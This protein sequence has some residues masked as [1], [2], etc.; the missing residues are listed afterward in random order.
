MAENIIIAALEAEV[1]YMVVEANNEAIHAKGPRVNFKP[2]P[3]EEITPF[4]KKDQRLDAIYDQEPL[5]FEKD[6]TTPTA[7]MMA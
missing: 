6:P 7:K 2:E 5:G 4:D 1:K 3:P